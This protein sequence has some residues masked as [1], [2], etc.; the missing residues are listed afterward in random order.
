[1]T[2]PAFSPVHVYFFSGSDQQ[3]WFLS[4]IHGRQMAESEHSKEDDGEELLAVDFLG[5]FL[6]TFVKVSVE[7]HVPRN[8]YDA[9]GAKGHEKGQTMIFREN[10]M[11]GS[12]YKRNKE[13]PFVN[14]K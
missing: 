6:A 11:S 13:N 14:G 12:K 9:H 7:H 3:G 4:Y 10:K 5:F 8:G 1:M 2:T